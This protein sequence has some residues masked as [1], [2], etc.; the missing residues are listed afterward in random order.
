VYFVD[1][2]DVVTVVRLMVGQLRDRA[3][4]AERADR[5]ARGSARRIRGLGV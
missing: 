4:R 3:D 1:D 5:A 2:P